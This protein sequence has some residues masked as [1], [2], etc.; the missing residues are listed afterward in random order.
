MASAGD[1]ARRITAT[2]TSQPL[3]IACTE[4][5]LMG[6]SRPCCSVKVLQ[7]IRANRMDTMGLR[8]EQSDYNQLSKVCGRAASVHILMSY[9]ARHITCRAVCCRRTGP[10]LMAA[11]VLSFQPTWAR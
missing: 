1:A 11:V 4:N 3:L 5:H 9:Q 10:T 6:L 8:G 7:A 2:H